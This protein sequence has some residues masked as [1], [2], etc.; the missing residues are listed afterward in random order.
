VAIVNRSFARLYLAGKDPLTVRFTAGYPNI[1]PKNVWTIIGVVDD[2]RQ[3]SLSVAPE[4]AYYTSSGQGTPRRQAFVVHAAG[5]DSAFLRS[6]IRDEARKLDPQMA[7]DIERASDIV[8]AGLSRQRLGM[9]LML[10]FG[11]AA[12]ALA[13]VGIYGVI[14]Y[15][16]AQRR[17]ELAIRLALGATPGNVFW[18]TLKHGRTLAL[19]GAT[20]GV[21]VAYLSGRVVSTW[22]Y[23]VQASDPV[24]LAAATTLV[25]GIALV[26]TTIPAYRAARLDPARVLRPE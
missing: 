8:S 12:V 6:A 4:P 9:A 15:G 2:I 5:G 14:A 3:R 25:V 24:I 7:V 19:A 26:A 1:D 16:A 20:I 18:L 13:A 11:L 21:V 22:L 10:G 23:E 17:N